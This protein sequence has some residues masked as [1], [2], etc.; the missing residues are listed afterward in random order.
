MDK[1]GWRIAGVTVIAAAVVIL[2]GGW[3]ANRLVPVTYPGELAFKPADDLPPVVDLASVQRSWPGL[4]EVPG[5][6]GRLL[7]YVHNIEHATP[8]TPVAPSVIAVPAAPVDLGTL[9]ASADAGVGKG[10][11]RV[12]TTCHSF[13][14]GGPDRVGPNLWGIV[15]RKIASRPGFAY[16]PAMAAQQGVWTYERIDHYLTSPARAIPG[17]KMAF[18]GLRRAE[19]RA[20]LVKYLGSMSASP[21]PLPQPLASAAS[22]GVGAP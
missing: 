11:A 15:G 21:P 3:F 2:S 13:D 17:N 8:P 18:A 1:K 16:S 10:K 22:E 5:E 19:D 6:R 9:L 14:R 20:A 12:C 7:A 4:I